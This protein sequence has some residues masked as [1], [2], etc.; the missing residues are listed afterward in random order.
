MPISLK[1]KYSG[2]PINS[3]IGPTTNK[4]DFNV[5]ASSITET[6]S[7]VRFINPIFNAMIDNIK[8]G[9]IMLEIINS[10]PKNTDNT[11]NDKKGVS[12]NVSK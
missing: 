12:I 7:I 2:K 11:A 9:Y 5:L 4:T 8:I 3:S 10:F 6:P 1:Y